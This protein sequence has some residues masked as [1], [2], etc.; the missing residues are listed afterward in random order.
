MKKTILAAMLLGFAA[1]PV[2]AG[3]C[4]SL[5]QKID[6]AMAAS[7]ADDATKAKIKELRDKAQTEHDGGN[8]DQS[9]ADAGEALK[10]LGM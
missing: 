8:H 1:A 4:P 5:I 6:E 9:V 2:M 3:Q 7:T 10:M